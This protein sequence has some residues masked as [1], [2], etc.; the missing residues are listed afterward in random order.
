M[1]HGCFVPDMALS[2]LGAG[3]RMA[4]WGFRACAIGHSECCALIRGFENA[5]AEDGSPVLGSILSIARFIGHQGRRKVSLAVPGCIRLTRDEVSLLTAF[6]AAQMKDEALRDAHLSWL[7]GRTAHK[8]LGLLADHV[9][10]RF[11][12]HGYDILLPATQQGAPQHRKGHIYSIAGGR[13]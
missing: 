8:Q 5:L 2:E 12:H 13:A 6:S 3:T 9:A 11:A 4:T 7:T 1:S 10:S